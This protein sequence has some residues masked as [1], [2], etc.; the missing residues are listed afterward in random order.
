NLRK[1][2]KVGLSEGRVLMTS[3]SGKDPSFHAFRGVLQ[4]VPCISN[5]PACLSEVTLQVGEAVDAQ[6]LLACS[7]GRTN[8][9]M[10][11]HPGHI[12]GNKD[13]MQPRLERW[14]HV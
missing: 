9:F 3:L 7:R 8:L 13:R 10:F 2:Q 6:Q 12:V 11:Q 1:F 14:I 5:D 4:P